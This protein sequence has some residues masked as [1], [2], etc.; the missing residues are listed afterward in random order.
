MIVATVEYIKVLRAKDAL[1][2]Q[3]GQAV[4]ETNLPE[5]FTGDLQEYKF[6]KMV[7]C[8]DDF[9]TCWNRG[10]VGYGTRKSDTYHN[11]LNEIVIRSEKTERDPETRVDKVINIDTPIAYCPWCHSPVITR[12]ILTINGIDS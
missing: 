8:C 5:Y 2:G 6:F 7:P 4:S 11:Q 1:T 12:E 10:I 9:T 3:N